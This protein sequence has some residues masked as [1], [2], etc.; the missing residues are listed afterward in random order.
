[1]T[2]M[3][4]GQTILVVEDMPINQ[5]LISLQLKKLGYSVQVTSNGREALAILQRRHFALILMD[6]QIPDMDGFEATRAIRHSERLD[7]HIPIVA[8]T[9]NAMAHHQAEYTK[10]GMDAMVAKPVKL[11]ELIAAIEQVITEPA[12]QDAEA[13]A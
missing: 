7:E 1:M 4:G 13:A 3:A 11:T 12:A 5:R 2:A 8:L 10:G 9:A 6:C